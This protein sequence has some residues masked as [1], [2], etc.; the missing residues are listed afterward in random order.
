IKRDHP[1]L[2]R[3]LVE[4]F[5]GV[6]KSHGAFATRDNISSQEQPIMFRPTALL[7]LSHLRELMLLSTAHRASGISELF[8]SNSTGSRSP[9]SPSRLDGQA[10]KATRQRSSPLPP[11]RLSMSTLYMERNDVGPVMDMNLETKTNQEESTA[12]TTSSSKQSVPSALHNED[13][14][15]MYNSTVEFLALMTA[16]VSIVCW[17]MRMLLDPN[18]SGQALP[19]ILGEDNNTPLERFLSLFDDQ[20]NVLKPISDALSGKDYHYQQSGDTRPDIDPMKQVGLFAWHF[21]L[22]ASD[23]NG[24]LVKDGHSIAVQRLQTAH[25]D[26]VLNDLYTTHV[27]SVTAKE[28]QKDHGQFYTPPGVVEFM[29]KRTLNGWGNMLDR[30][31]ETIHPE[32][33]RSAGDVAPVGTK[34][35]PSD[36]LYNLL[37]QNEPLIPT[38]LDP[39]LGVSTFLSN[40]IRLLIQEAMSGHDSK[41]WNSEAASRLLL[42]QI[43]E[44]VWGIE[45]DG[46]AFWMARCGVIA[47][48]MPLV[49]RTQELHAYAQ[50]DELHLNNNMLQPHNLKLPRLHLFRN[51][52]LQLSVPRVVDS[53]TEWESRCILLLRDPT[54]LQFDF[55][56]TN[57]PYMIRKTGTF[58]APDPD[59]YDWSILGSN[60]GSNIGTIS[61]ANSLRGSKT[62]Q[63]KK[64]KDV[65]LAG[66]FPD[67]GLLPMTETDSDRAN[68]FEPEVVTPDANANMSKSSLQLRSAPKGMMQV[69]GYFILFAAQRVKPY[70]GISCMITASQW[71][72]LGFASKLRAWLFE[73]CLMDEFFQFEPFKVFSK[74]QT[75]SLIFK[76]RALETSTSNPAVREKALLDHRT[77]FLRHTDHHKPLAGIL[78]DYMESSI[79]IASTGLTNDLSIMVSS[80]TRK[81]LSLAI[82]APLSNSSTPSAD[83]SS[84]STSNQTSAWTYSFAPMMPSSGLTTYLLSLTQDLGGICSAGTKKLNRLSAVEPL[85][86]HRGPNTN[87]VYGLVTRMEYARAN[88]GETMAIKWFRPALYWNGK[89]SPEDLTSGEGDGDGISGSGSGSGNT[90]RTLHKEGLFWRSRDRMRLSKK[91]G[92]P[93]E[94]YVVPKS[95]P[96][97]QYALC[98][99]DKDSVK[100]LRAQVEQEVEGSLKLWNYLKDVRDH[101]QPG[102]ASKKRKVAPNGGRQGADDDGVAFCS[103]NQCGSDIAEKIIH[104]INYGYFSKTQPRQRFFLDTDN[105]AVTN[106]CIYL[107]QNKLSNHYN[108]QQS[109]PPLVYFL[110]L[111]NSSTLQFFILHYCQYDQQGRMRL[112]RESM[113][114]IP[115]QDQDVKSNIERA[116]YGSQLGRH[117]ID[118]KKLVYR[119][120][121]CWGLSGGNRERGSVNKTV[122]SKNIASATLGK[123]VLKLDEP[124]HR[125]STSASGSNHGLLDWIRRGGDA[126][127]GVL[128]RTKEQ[129][130]YMLVTETT[131]TIPITTQKIKSADPSFMP[132]SNRSQ[133]FNISLVETDTD[134]N[135]SGE[136]DSDTDDNTESSIYERQGQPISSRFFNEDRNVLL[137]GTAAA[138]TTETWNE[139]PQ[140][141]FMTSRKAEEYVVDSPKAKNHSLISD[142]VIASSNGQ[143][144]AYRESTPLQAHHGSFPLSYAPDTTEPPSHFETDVDVSSEC[145]KILQVIERAIAM[146]EIIQWAV[147]QYG[148]MLYGIQP[149]FQKLLE[150]ELKLVYSST[151]EAMVI[152]TSATP[153]PSGLSPSSRI[154]GSDPDILQAF[155][156][157]IPQSEKQQQLQEEAPAQ[158]SYAAVASRL[159]ITVSGLYR[160]SFNEDGEHSTN[161]E[162][163]DISAS[164]STPNHSKIPT[165]AKSILDNAKM[166][167]QHIE[168]LLQRYPC[169]PVEKMSM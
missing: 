41:I 103:T 34:E 77:I 11:S 92:S 131:V 60:F 33:Y 114:K 117:M 68:E 55:I 93:A 69:Y 94:S 125:A 135:T 88:F 154:P 14:A 162:R 13:E 159:G 28:H 56:V 29:W 122:S 84:T 6:L 158:P 105:H 127:A 99:I 23:P 7:S 161:D 18:T 124:S 98:M 72:T 167:A 35:I 87:P 40:Y 4:L 89:N 47:A 64:L 108:A 138:R 71:L 118:L 91:E 5:N 160:W 149:K 146:L 58:S 97:R 12:S 73:N 137:D 38:A 100:V 109:P 150:L 142:Q 67:E 21:Y 121:S 165:Y 32:Q 48:L 70:T 153:S 54:Q 22:F 82:T 168:D 104:P 152:P 95:D 157:Q 136:T 85:L 66:F 81:E 26:V 52:T 25:F 45:L 15:E 139:A 2:E 145:D 101:F 102:L 119:A 129:I 147:D 106:Q 43:C 110:M 49:R 112:F 120:I 166:A 9:S 75:D 163:D 63:N 164:Q 1:H 141:P 10:T 30:F 156:Q 151:I 16:F 65:N 31:V 140:D 46:F 83:G 62:K 115:F 57:P 134:T 53:Y 107:T 74:V 80:K 143:N 59:V 155:P 39:C 113:A 61:G 24:P 90:S 19:K 17:L 78:Q 8:T 169:L 126:P 36:I 96:H 86:W 144:S 133:R 20:D 42:H 50:G 37:Q 51:D 148:Y 3:V 130:R 128:A 111:L 44:H 76:V 79:S 27:L 116:K 123:G 132:P